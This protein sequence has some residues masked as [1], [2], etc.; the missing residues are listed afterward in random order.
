[1]RPRCQTNLPF[2]AGV[3]DDL[4]TKLTLADAADRDRDLSKGD[5]GKVFTGVSRTRENLGVVDEL[6]GLWKLEDYEDTL[7]ELEEILL[8]SDFGPRTSQRL[9]DTL[10]DE[11][12]LHLGYVQ[13]AIAL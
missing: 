4:A 7:D 5:V 11:V 3:A 1:M 12:G 6:L 8:V 9:V 10:R 13:C 2:F